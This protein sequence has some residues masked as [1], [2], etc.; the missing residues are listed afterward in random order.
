MADSGWS[1]VINRSATGY[2]GNRPHRFRNHVVGITKHI[3]DIVIV[4]N[5]CS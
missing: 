4:T 5:S 3:C 1:S 2:V